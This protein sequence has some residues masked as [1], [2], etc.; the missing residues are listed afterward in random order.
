[1]HHISS[2]ACSH[3]LKPICRHLHLFRWWAIWAGLTSALPSK[4][5]CC[6]SS[7]PTALLRH[8][9]ELPR[10]KVMSCVL[11]GCRALDMPPHASSST[12]SL[13]S[14]TDCNVLEL[15]NSHVFILKV[16][17]N[18][19]TLFD[20]TGEPGFCLDTASDV[21]LRCCDSKSPFVF[22]SIFPVT[23]W[24]LYVNIKVIP[25]LLQPHNPHWKNECY[26]LALFTALHV[27]V[28]LLP[29][30]PFLC[31]PHEL[32]IHPAVISLCIAWDNRVPSPAVICLEA[33]IITMFFIRQTL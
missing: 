3:T 24:E 18:P 2:F 6:A 26:A 12:T 25:S 9:D 30:L 21:H 22:C 17:F 7:A 19:P 10:L 29:M 4:T 1:M 11:S 23:P 31:H 8:A 32:R 5:R 20:D 33:A 28:L 16:L 15:K 14:F 13:P 27:M